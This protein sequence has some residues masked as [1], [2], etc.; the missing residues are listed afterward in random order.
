MISYI[1]NNEKVSSAMATVFHTK[2]PSDKTLE[3]VNF[4]QHEIE[5][6]SSLPSAVNRYCE[7]TR[8]FLNENYSCHGGG[9]VAE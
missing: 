8:Q 9:S 7:L 3:E 5:N 4:Q 6:D 2:Q 1:L